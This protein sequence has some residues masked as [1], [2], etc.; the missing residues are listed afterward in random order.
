[1]AE[2]PLFS[3]DNYTLNLTNRYGGLSTDLT[4]RFS[5][6]N[7]GF[8]FDINQLHKEREQLSSNLM[9]NDLV[10]IDK[11]DIQ[12]Y[13][14]D[15]REEYS[16]K[17]HDD[18]DNFFLT[19]HRYRTTEVTAERIENVREKDFEL[20]LSM[21]EKF[22]K[23]VFGDNAYFSPF[24]TKDANGNDLP[25]HEIKQRIEMFQ[26]Q[27]LHDLDWM[28]D[29]RKDILDNLAKRQWDLGDLEDERYIM[30]KQQFNNPELIQH[31]SPESY[32]VIMSIKND[33]TLS[34][35]EKLK[36]YFEICDTNA[37]E[38]G[39]LTVEEAKFYNIEASLNSNQKL[40]DYNRQLLGLNQ[41]LTIGELL[42]QTLHEEKSPK[43]QFETEQIQEIDKVIN[44]IKNNQGPDL[45]KEQQEQL[46]Q[47]IDHQMN[48]G[49]EMEAALDRYANSPTSSPS[50]GNTQDLRNKKNYQN[51]PKPR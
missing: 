34:E 23:E 21:M 45:T 3:S 30:L 20:S 35:D 48:A 6:Y 12:E 37:V 19:Q 31:I 36:K 1:M 22:N 4:Q 10:K 41:D 47:A 8:D 13:L 27:V 49:S 50:L 15:L 14:D 29:S 39:V 25:E 17:F 32:D 9:K 24:A 5:I 28:Q 26:N 44:D 33:D 51:S 40:Q 16:E 11:D 18:V 7:I 2:Q 42:Q 46:N 43:E 38:Q